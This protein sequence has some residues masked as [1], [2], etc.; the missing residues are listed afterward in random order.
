MLE[1]YLG[2]PFP[3]I[4]DTYACDQVTVRLNGKTDLPCTRLKTFKI[5]TQPF[6]NVLIGEL[7]TKGVQFTLATID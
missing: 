7:K 4:M 2:D 6:L 1:D 5:D 3:Q